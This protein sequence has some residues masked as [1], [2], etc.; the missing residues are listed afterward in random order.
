MVKA[1]FLSGFS[2]ATLLKNLNRRPEMTNKHTT[3]WHRLADAAAVARNAADRILAAA[4]EA[5]ARQGVFRLVLAGGRT[6]QATYRLL[7][8]A[9]ADWSRWQIYFGD[10]RCLPPGHTDR[11]SSMAATAWLDHVGMRR[12]QVHVIPAE[13]G[14]TEGARLYDPV[15]AAAL[16]FDLVLLGLGEDGHTASLFPGHPQQRE[17][18]VIPVTGAPK[19]PAERVSLSAKALNQSRQ[20]LV[21]VTGKEKRPAVKNWQAGKTLPV[22][23]ISPRENLTVLLDADADIDTEH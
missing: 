1:F 18:L 15:V 6:P 22:T 9:D 12:Q 11:N 4:S 17:K 7:R 20:I 21:L 19:P 14:P 5:I 3:T 8:N 16:P 2:L 13:L 23:R 10:E